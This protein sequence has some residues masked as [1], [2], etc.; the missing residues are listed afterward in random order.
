MISAEDRVIVARIAFEA[1]GAALSSVKE[2]DW[3]DLDEGAQEEVLQRFDRCIGSLDPSVF[4]KVVRSTAKILKDVGLVDIEEDELAPVTAFDKEPEPSLRAD[5]V[6][7]G[8]VRTDGTV[9]PTVSPEDLI[10]AGTPEEGLES[11]PG[12]ADTAQ[13]NHRT[14]PGGVAPELEFAVRGD[15]QLPDGMT[16][17]DAD[18]LAREADAAR[19][20]TASIA[21]LDDDELDELTKP[22]EQ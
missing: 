21:D 3:N 1:E 16:Q 7:G 2:Q 17:E 11:Y 15:I 8:V 19:L 9:D 12:E 13:P 5:I 20:D 22:D 14:E 6:H 4:G 18:R 10:T